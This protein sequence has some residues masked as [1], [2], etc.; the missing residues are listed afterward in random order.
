ML[1]GICKFKW[2]YINTRPVTRP[3]P[4][5]RFHTVFTCIICVVASDFTFHTA[6]RVAVTH[7][8]LG[9]RYFYLRD[10][11]IVKV[12]WASHVSTSWNQQL[13]AVDFTPL[14]WQ[15]K[16]DPLPL[17][18]PSFPVK[19]AEHSPH[20]G[21]P[22][23]FVHRILAADKLRIDNNPLAIWSRIANVVHTVVSMRTVFY[24]STAVHSL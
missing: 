12:G 1:R 11:C 15:Q 3:F 8:N 10:F 14:G 13:G 24:V 4:S 18:C 9:K 5:V 2:E 21:K 22:C 19:A 17:A 23:G 6:R 7:W 16:C 20:L